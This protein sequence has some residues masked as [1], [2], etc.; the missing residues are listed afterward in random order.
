VK[1]IE[2]LLKILGVKFE[3]ENLKIRFHKRQVSFLVVKTAKC[4]RDISYISVTALYMRASC[5]EGLEL[6]PG[7]AK[8]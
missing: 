2:S 8:S 3:F 4:K 6:N 1:N 5:A 7:P